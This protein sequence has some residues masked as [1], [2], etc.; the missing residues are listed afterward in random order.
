MKNMKQEKL[1]KTKYSRT[2][3]SGSLTEGRAL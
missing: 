1:V 2:D 3:K